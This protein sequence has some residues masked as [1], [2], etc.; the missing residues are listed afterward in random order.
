ML[1][2]GLAAGI[3]DTTVFSMFVLEALVLTFGTT[4]MTLYLYPV[5]MRKRV[6]VTGHDFSAV[7]T[8]LQ[9]ARAAKN[10]LTHSSHFQCLVEDAE[11]GKG[12]KRK[13]T[14]SLP[15]G[16]PKLRITVVLDKIE[17]VPALM[18]VRFV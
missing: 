4:P 9:L 3:L 1:N 18:T 15:F 12:P 8:S 7:G 13:S 11:E 5:S 6:T 2:I 10:R 17:H 14:D 16:D